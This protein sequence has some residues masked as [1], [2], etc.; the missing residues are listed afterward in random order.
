MS[1]AKAVRVDKQNWW[2]LPPTLT[3]RFKQNNM[4]ALTKLALAATMLICAFSAQAEWVS[5]YVRSSGTYVQPYY[6]SPANG[7]PYDNLSY[8]GYPSQHPGY[9]S[10]RSY[11]YT[12]YTPGYSTYTYSSTPYPSYSSSPYS[13]PSSYSIYGSSTQIGGMTFHNYYSSNGGNLSGTTLT[14]GNT[15]FTSLYGW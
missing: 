2:R 13:Y 5:G 12:S 3:N 7:T 14:I 4:K 11:G 8:R 15:S 1:W 9:V 10:P 6:R